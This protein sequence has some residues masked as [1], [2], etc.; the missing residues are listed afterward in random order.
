MGKDHGEKGLPKSFKG[1]CC[2]TGAELR[3]SSSSSVGVRLSERGV[4]LDLTV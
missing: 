2:E 4:R 1:R 3:G